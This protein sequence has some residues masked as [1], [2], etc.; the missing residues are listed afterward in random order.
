MRRGKRPSL[1]IME[2]EKEGV[3]EMDEDADTDRKVG[4]N[5]DIIIR[6][7]RL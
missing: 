3:G 5:I 6:Q 2:G 7:S 4:R 1:L